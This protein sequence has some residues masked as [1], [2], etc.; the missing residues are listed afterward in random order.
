MLAFL[1]QRI[2][3]LVPTL[4]FVSVIIFAAFL[5]GLKQYEEIQARSA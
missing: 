3:Q 2:L 4:F 5:V 1:S